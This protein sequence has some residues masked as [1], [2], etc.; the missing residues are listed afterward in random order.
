MFKRDRSFI[1]IIA[2]LIYRI[3]L[4][5][6]LGD[7]GMGYLFGPM[8]VF[9]GLGLLFG[10]GLSVTMQGMMRDRV[11]K[12]Q[13][14]NAGQVFSLGRRY[15][16][17]A[18]IVICAV[19]VALYDFISSKILL[20]GGQRLAYLLTGPGAALFILLSLY[21]GYIS[22]TENMSAM[23][24]G[25]IFEAVSIGAGMIVGALIG[26]SYGTGIAAL[27]RNED[28]SAMYGAMGAM[29][30]LCLGE[31]LGLIAFIVMTIIYQ[32]SFRHLVKGDPS[33]RT[34]YSSD[35]SRG[36][37]SGIIMDGMQNLLI[38]LP[39]LILII[40][41]RKNGIALG[42]ENTNAMAGAF[43]AKYLGVTGLLS[44][45]AV[46]VIPH[47]I[48]GV[49]AALN[50]GEEKYASERLS[51]LVGRVLYFVIPASIFT[52]MLAPAIMEA[53]FKGMITTV[54]SVLISCSAII[55]LFALMYLFTGILVRLGY[56][57]EVLFISAV[58]LI[59][60]IVLGIFMLIKKDGGL[61]WVA[62]ILMINYGLNMLLCLFVLL[63]NMRFR[64]MPMQQIIIPLVI[65]GVVGI[66]LKLLSGAILESAGG[67]L[68]LT[69]CVI[70]GWIIYNIACIFFRSVSAFQME[71]KLF[72]RIFV[73]IGRNMG[74]Y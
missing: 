55:V 21:K 70:P 24:V 57:R 41:Y 11:R 6:I 18:A 56:H 34:E 48:K 49:M 66:I 29:L 37:F 68:T 64:T 71:R 45:M 73:A 53:L 9:L 13:Y 14:K 1:I 43:Y 10:S 74:I 15:G 5:H 44:L 35:V 23:V 36:L 60:S 65:S 40:L 47:G 72:G 28:V 50:E 16:I 12:S 22:G 59:I 17:I 46:T 42:Q 67:V 19:N 3:P 31:L 30:G 58:T 62:L 8:E 27:L 26:R 25:E 52:A 38:I 32:R 61:L 69:V 4:S 7:M 51:K 2:L 20:D 63:R 39:I 33:R 54:S